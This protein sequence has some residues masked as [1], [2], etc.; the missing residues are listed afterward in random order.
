MGWVRY[1]WDRNIELQR[2]VEAFEAERQKLATQQ[3]QATSEVQKLHSQIEE[4]KREGTRLQQQLKETQAPPTSAAPKA[5]SATS[6]DAAACQPVVDQLKQDCRRIR[7]ERD[8][9]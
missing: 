8:Q 4:L 6:D 9:F 5:P 7:G 1:I 2:Q 3:I